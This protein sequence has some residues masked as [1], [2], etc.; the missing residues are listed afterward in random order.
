M[1]SKKSKR[2]KKLEKRQ[3]QSRV[4]VAT[5]LQESNVDDSWCSKDILLSNPKGSVAVIEKSSAVMG[6]LKTIIQSMTEKSDLGLTAKRMKKLAPMTCDMLMEGDSFAPTDIG[7][8][9]SLLFRRRNKIDIKADLDV[10]R[11]WVA[12]RVAAALTPFF[13]GLDED[14]LLADPDAASIFDQIRCDMEKKILAKY[15]SQKTL[16]F[17]KH[18]VYGHC[19]KMG[20]SIG[21]TRQIWQTRRV[22]ETSG[23]LQPAF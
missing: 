20:Q 21:Q 1:P 13:T 3:Q 7:N 9:A 16:L 18:F 17:D 8:A 2:Q 15:R 23:S 5:V 10:L 6:E 14:D 11:P 22:F 19:L 12:I 4:P